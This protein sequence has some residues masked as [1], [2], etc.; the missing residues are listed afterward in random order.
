MWTDAR[1]MFAESQQMN[2]SDPSLFNYRVV[3]ITGKVASIF[4]VQ[5]T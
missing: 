2:F 4:A 1:S 5:Y 3:T